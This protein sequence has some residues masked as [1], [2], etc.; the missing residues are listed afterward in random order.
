MSKRYYLYK[1]EDNWA[2]EADFSGFAVFTEEEKRM[3]EAGIKKAFKNG[4]SICFGTNEDNDYD[5]Y[6][7]VESTF[8]FEE[9]TK[10][11]YFTIK[12]LFGET[13]GHLGPL[14][15][16]GSYEADDDDEDDE[17]EEED[18][19]EVCGDYDDTGS[20]TC[21]EC[22]NDE[23]VGE[24]VEDAKAKLEKEFGIELS[25]KGKYKWKPTPVTT[26]E[27]SIGE[28]DGFAD[29]MLFKGKS[30]MEHEYFD[31]DLKDIVKEVKKIIKIAQNL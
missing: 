3:H 26:I 23:E 27:I 16:F 31:L 18:T 9:I 17:D 14:D 30:V 8:S 24:L 2:D 12:R 21:T 15:E 1:F 19:C 22:M 11:E 28:N 4:G 13:F 7:D 29:I 5:S 10:Q 25:E 20:G 6:E